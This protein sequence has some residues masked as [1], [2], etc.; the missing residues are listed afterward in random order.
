MDEGAINLKL[1]GYEISDI[2]FLLLLVKRLKPFD[3]PKK[4]PLA[5]IFL[6]GKEEGDIRS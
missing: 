6:K 1:K 3:T 2:L 5:G 4:R